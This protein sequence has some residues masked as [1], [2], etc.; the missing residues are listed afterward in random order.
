VTHVLLTIDWDTFV[1]ITT[2]V[3]LAGYETAL[4]LKMAWLYR[5]RL[6]EKM[7]LLG[8]ERLFWQRLA[9]QFDVLSAVDLYVSDSHTLA[10]AL[11]ERVDHV[12][13]VDR[14]HDC[15]RWPVVDLVPVEA[16][17]VDC[18]NWAAA[19]LSRSLQRTLHWVYPDRHSPKGCAEVMH[20]VLPPDDPRQRRW[21]ARSL[22]AFLD[23][24]AHPYLNTTKQLTLHVC[25]SGCWT[26]P[27][28][29]H[30]FKAFL[31]TPGLHLNPMQEGV[32]DPL[33]PRWNLDDYETARLLYEADV[34]H[35]RQ[36]Q[37]M[38]GTEA[39]TYSAKLVEDTWL[40]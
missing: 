34:A 5:Y 10:Y 19:W 39:A 36:M 22:T 28:L 16:V 14:H 38:C 37:K 15:Y 23:D 13:L 21:S 33:K 1:N 32:W 29:D 2:D 35:L 24:P 4:N 18:G 9:C 40:K 7:Q 25:R 26:P 30:Q 17:S 12:I 27:W 6:M 3:D 11:A 8:E 31:E 20:T